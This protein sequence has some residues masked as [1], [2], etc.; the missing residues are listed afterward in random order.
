MKKA[1]PFSS[2]MKRKKKY[3]TEWPG[4]DVVHAL[5]VSE[6]SGTKILNFVDLTT[7]K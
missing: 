3:Y 7:L 2:L 1:S 6:F 4:M 5:S